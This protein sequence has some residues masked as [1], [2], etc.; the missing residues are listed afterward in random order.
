MTLRE[1]MAIAICNA[2]NRNQTEVWQQFLP[3]AD[4][5]L[6][7]LQDKKISARE[8]SKNWFAGRLAA[9]IRSHHPD[10]CIKLDAFPCSLTQVWYDGV[11]AA[12]LFRSDG[13]PVL[14]A[15]ERDP[16][17]AAQLL[18][19]FNRV[20]RLLSVMDEPTDAMIEAGY[21]AGYGERASIEAVYRAMIKA[22]RE[23]PV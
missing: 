11:P 1:K 4:A 8:H 22:A 3:E 16:E 14:S 13:T 15:P 21:L 6:A 2:K 12:E 23:E 20:G 9:A 5:V 10:D 17:V 18:E 7:V 19:M